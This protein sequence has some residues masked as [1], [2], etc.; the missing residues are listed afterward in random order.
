MACQ[1]S[2]TNNTVA[3]I[4]LGL[5]GVVAFAVSL[6][7]ILEADTWL[8][9]TAGLYWWTLYAPLAFGIL[10]FVVSAVGCGVEDTTNHRTQILSLSFTLSLAVFGAIVLA[11]GSSLIVLVSSYMPTI[12]TSSFATKG[13][14]TFVLAGTSG[15]FGVSNAWNRYSSRSSRTSTRGV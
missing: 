12:A 15:R 11:A 6:H 9:D 3:A 14:C 5:F 4:L 13:E 8:P 1:P 2:F 10:A 7:L